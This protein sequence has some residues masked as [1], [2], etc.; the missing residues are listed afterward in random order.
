MALS[1]LEA[2]CVAH[3][4][5]QGH[6]PRP[7]PETRTRSPLH[8]QD[9]QQVLLF[10]GVVSQKNWLLPELSVEVPISGRL[11]G[12]GGW[13]GESTVGKLPHTRMMCTHSLTMENCKHREPDER[14]PLVP[15]FIWESQSL[16]IYCSVKF[17][18][19]LL[20]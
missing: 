11:T 15:D 3:I 16:G 10:Q 2:G 9:S 14:I 6:P 5:C 19:S 1:C 17:L 13:L 12:R 8:S 18:D 7:C 4:S 20:W